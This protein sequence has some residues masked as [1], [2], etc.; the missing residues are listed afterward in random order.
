MSDL[1]QAAPRALGRILHPTDFSAG[2]ETA[3]VHGLKLAL[4]GKG[5]FHLVHAEPERMPDDADWAAFPG[6]RDTL[7]R[8]GL[9]EQGAPTAAVAQK[10]GLRVTKVD[11]DDRKPMHAILRFLEEHPCDLIVL[12]THGREGL[13]RLMR[14]SVAEPLARQAQLPTLFLPHGCF[15][16]VDAR[17]GEVQLR[18]VLIPVAASP[19]ASPAISEAVEL[20]NGLGASGTVFH[21]LH[22]G[23]DELATP[24]EPRYEPR[25]RRLRR[26]GP[27]VETIVQIADEVAA[28]LVVMATAGHEGFL[29]AFRGSTT[30]QVLRQAKRAMLAVPA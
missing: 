27:V 21:L 24:V 12:A 22:V 11:V 30:E 5:H 2:G 1:N 8:W 18:N 14:G 19:S 23:A 29:D 16:F 9:L 10:L 17:N 7:A 6:V 25:L 28:D 20:A 4:T 26:S 13:P 15:G 3:F